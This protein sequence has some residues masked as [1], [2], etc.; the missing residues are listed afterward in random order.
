MN[1]VTEYIDNAQQSAAELADRY[2]SLWNEAD[3]DRRRELI[4]G[5][6][7][8][9]GEHILQPPEE[10]RRIAATPG[11][12]GSAIIEA[13]GH[14]EIDARATSAYEHWVATQG[15]SF[16]RRDDAD[17]VHDVIKFHWEAVDSDGEVT[18]AGLNLL[19]LDAQGRI[20]RDYTFVDG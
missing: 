7:R 10:A 15:W 11:V 18:G 5:L 3:P 17:R 6:W 2:V 9:D 20:T 4:A 1:E 16:R 13:R 19:M 14:V 12:G 8:E